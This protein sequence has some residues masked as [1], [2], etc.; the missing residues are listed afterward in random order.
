METW[1]PELRFDK[2]MLPDWI[3]ATFRELSAKQPFG[4]NGRVSLGFAIDP[5]FCSQDE[6]RQVFAEARLSGAHL[7][8][9]HGT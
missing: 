9:S 1:Q 7:I 3:M 8:T 6:L 5:G 2:D 4:P